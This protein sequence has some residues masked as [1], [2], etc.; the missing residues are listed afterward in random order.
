MRRAHK[1]NIWDLYL[2]AATPLVPRRLRIGVT[3]RID[4]AGK[5]VLPLV[6]QDVYR[7]CELLKKEG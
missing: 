5:V 7:A 2:P 4:A 3:E 6:E 1:E